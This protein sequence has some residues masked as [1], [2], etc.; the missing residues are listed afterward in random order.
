MK[1]NTRY[2]VITADSY[3]VIANGFYT[4]TSACEWAERHDYG[5]F[6]DEGGLCVMSY[7]LE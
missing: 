6:E 1:N 5:Q 7:E 2:Q 3:R 4:W